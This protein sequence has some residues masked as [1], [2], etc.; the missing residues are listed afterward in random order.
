MKHSPRWVVF[1]ALLVSLCATARA[2][3]HQQGP[4]VRIESYDGIIV[5]IHPDKSFLL[6]L[7]HRSQSLYLDPDGSA[8]LFDDAGQTLATGKWNPKDGSV[9]GIGGLP[10]GMLDRVKRALAYVKT[11]PKKTGP[12]PQSAGKPSSEQKAASAIEWVNEKA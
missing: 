11:L 7:P 9:T 8:M 1:S 3:V 6:N 5:K 4:D 12:P 2:D 10:D